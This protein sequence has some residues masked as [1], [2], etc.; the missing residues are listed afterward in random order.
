MWL[1]SSLLHCVKQD[2]WKSKWEFGP[3]TSI[4]RGPALGMRSNRLEEIQNLLHWWPLGKHL[5]GSDTDLK[6]LLSSASCARLYFHLLLLLFPL[7][8]L[9]MAPQ[10]VVKVTQ[11]APW[12]ALMQKMWPMSGVLWAGVRTVGSLV[13]L[14]CTHKLPVIMTGLATMWQGVSFHGTISEGQKIKCFLH[15]TYAKIVLF[16]NQLSC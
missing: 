14:A 11:E 7:Q 5:S 12:S 3:A 8:V 4:K 2:W 6:N 1:N 10:T 15:I 9:M 13:T 16:H